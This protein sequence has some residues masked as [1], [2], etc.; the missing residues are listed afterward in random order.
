MKRLQ[1]PKNKFA[2]LG[3]N[4]FAVLICCLLSAL[5]YGFLIGICDFIVINKSFPFCR[6]LSFGRLS[7]PLGP[8]SFSIMWFSSSFLVSRFIWFG[9]IKPRPKITR[10]KD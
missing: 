2:R 5:I 1:L 8:Y 6:L 3:I 10:S 9:R 7:N 4:I